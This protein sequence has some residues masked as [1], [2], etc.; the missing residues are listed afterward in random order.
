MKNVTYISAGAGSGKTYTLTQ[1]LCGLIKDKKIAPEK[2]ILTTF[3]IQAAEEFREK[4]KGALYELGRF[5][6]AQRLDQAMIG[7]VHSVCCR[8]VNKYWFELGLTPDMGVMPSTDDGASHDYYQSLSLQNLPTQKDLEFMYRYAR[9]FDIQ[10]YKNYL[11][12]GLNPHFWKEDLERVISLATNYEI[13][14]FSLSLQRSL[15]FFD[16]LCDPTAHFTVSKEEIKEACDAY[17]AVQN[18]LAQSKTRDD[19]IQTLKGLLP[20]LQHPTF[21]WC[22]QLANLFKQVNKDDATVLAILPKLE[23]LWLSPEVRDL[24]REYLT[25]LFDMAARW[26]KQ[27]REFKKKKALLDYNDMEMYMLQLLDKPEVR[28][29]IKQDFEYLFV[30]EFQDSSPIQVKI[31]DRLSELMKESY[32]VGDYK[33]SIYGFRGSDLGLVKA[34]TDK[35]EKGEGGHCDKPLEKSHRS[36]P[37]L[38]NLSNTIFTR[39]FAGILPE[40]KI[41]LDPYNPDKPDIQSLRYFVARGNKEVV[42]QKIARYIQSLIC[43]E[44][45]EADKIGVLAYK[46]DTLSDVAKQLAEL[47]IPCSQ[48]DLTLTETKTYQLMSALLTLIE[49]PHDTLAK[50]T[51]AAM[52]EKDYGLRRIIEERILYIESHLSENGNYTEEAEYLQRNPILQRLTA[53]RQ[54][55]LQKS[56]SAMTESLIAVLDLHSYAQALEDAP[57]ANS[58][59]QTLVNAARR[60]EQICVQMNMAATVPGFLDYVFTTDP[61]ASGDP[62]G[63]KLYTYHSSKGLEAHHIIMLSLSEEIDDPQDI[64]KKEVYGVHADCD[65]AASAANPYPQKFIRVSRNL[66]PGN[67]KMPAALAERVLTSPLFEP[68][69]VR[70]IAECNRLLYV[71]VTR[72]RDVL[73]LCIPVGQKSST[74][75][76]HRFRAAGWNSCDKIAV[77]EGDWTPFGPEHVFRD[78]TTYTNGMESAEVQPRP[79]L[80]TVPVTDTGVTYGARYISPSSLHAVGKILNYQTFPE[81]H[82]IYHAKADE[83][84]VIGDCIHQ[85]YA[86]MPA[87]CQEGST[88]SEA[89]GSRVPAAEIIAAWGLTDHITD[90]EAI[91][92]S[93]RKLCVYL[94]QTYGPAT[95]VIHEYPFILEENGQTLTGSIDLIW[96]TSKGDIIVDFKTTNLP[97]ATL[98]NPESER[99]AGLYAGQLAAYR[100]ALEAA[101]RPVLSTLLYYPI[102]GILAECTL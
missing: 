62:H 16:N 60:Y 66:F 18:R 76:L 63:V 83:A 70:R 85:V 49:R 74:A 11:P 32:W 59:L 78:C 24:H 51:V 92:E 46:K 88:E 61:K 87:S 21:G 68:A 3:S 101:G 22:N 50:A 75:S 91:E 29:E 9:E 73:H 97:A 6:E 100:R 102:A 15:E 64:I 52:T 10:E 53:L 36:L 94:T 23:R 84:R 1:K 33:Q 40:D 35:L 5:A 30:D 2:V 27:Y 38:V 67:T 93:W 96:R 95:E 77:P 56:L 4:V 14:D 80:L 58:A 19:R 82:K 89:S 13:T 39:T 31:F 81:L 54:R 42:A 90:P 57:T 28:E 65:E 71:G 17:K 45:V 69:K 98:L 26:Q 41:R 37:P 12:I 99:F 55:M 48:S 86:T 25:R 7:T 79:R 72:A 43:S 8:M 20:G 44:K 47:K 34:V